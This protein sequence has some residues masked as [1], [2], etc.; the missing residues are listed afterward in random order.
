MGCF[1]LI[2]ANA[3]H[4][5]RPIRSGT[6]NRFAIRI[7]VAASFLVAASSAQANLLTN[8]SFELPPVPPGSFTTFPAG[9]VLIPGWTVFGPAGTD[10]AIVSTTFTQSGVSFPAQEGIQWMDLTG[11]NSNSTEG[12]S[13]AVTT[14][15]GNQYQLS[16]HVGNTTGGTIFGTT[17]TVNVLLNGS[18]TFTDVNDTVSAATLNWEQ[19]THT[20]IASGALSTL[21]FQNGDPSNDNSNGLDNVVLLDLGPAVSPVP[22]PGTLALLAI[23]LATFGMARKRKRA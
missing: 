8:G 12:V 10:V 17:S 3:G 18:L 4:L 14:M 6:M 9:S 13:Q 7:A 1:L 5:N 15:P 22:E 11:L 19:F 16:L 2:V 21:A 23:G 20:F